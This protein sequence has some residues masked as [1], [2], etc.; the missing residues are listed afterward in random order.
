M[1]LMLLLS[2]K[3]LL[4]QNKSNLPLRADT[5]SLVLVN[6]NLIK[7][8]NFKLL[9]RQ[10]LKAIVAQQDTIIFDLHNLV[11]LK[12][13]NIKELTIANYNSKLEN[14]ELVRI[15]SELGNK[16]NKYKKYNGI[17]AGVSVTAIIV[18]VLSIVIQ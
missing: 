18:S 15:N 7:E 6:I 13:N 5:D 12:D 1:I 2:S 9:E 4:G 14:E 8:A 10:E 17:L 11:N 3:S 16:L